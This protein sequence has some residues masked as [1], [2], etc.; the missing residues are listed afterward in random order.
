MS[1]RFIQKT[2][3]TVLAFAILFVAFAS[4][5]REAWVAWVGVFFSL[6]FVMLTLMFKEPA[7]EPI[8]EDWRDADNAWAEDFKFYAETTV[9]QRIDTEQ[10]LRD[11][12][13]NELVQSGWDE[14]AA[15]QVVRQEREAAM[16][17]GEH[18][19]HLN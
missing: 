7:A 13:T 15:R 11:S 8:N 9:N 6:A 10:A 2:R 5:T 16:F 19:Q 14:A 12:M 17:S 1:Q 18:Y 3:L 4:L